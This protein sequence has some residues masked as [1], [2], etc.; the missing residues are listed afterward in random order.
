MSDDNNEANNPQ[1]SKS[2]TSE[3][4]G[5][6]LRRERVTRRIAVETIAKDLKLN[7]AY[8]KAIE[9]NNFDHLPASPYVRVYLRSIANYLMLN[10]DEILEKYNKDAGTKDLEKDKIETKRIK[11]DI[12]QD[13]QKSSLLWNISIILILIIIGV[14]IYYVGKKMNWIQGNPLN[15]NDSMSVE[16]TYQEYAELADSLNENIDSVSVKDTLSDIQDSIDSNMN[17]TNKEDSLR[18]AIT[19]MK[20]SVWIQIFFDGKSWKNFIKIGQTRVFYA[21]DSL[22]THVGRNSYLKYN[23]NGKRLRIKGQ[24]VRYF[25]IDHDGMET[26]NVDQ[27]NSIFKNRL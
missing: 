21:K 23:L 15:K 22:N 16:T 5:D 27:W 12:K 4:V 10:S 19:A 1:Q 18:F 9:L 13:R 20:D 6:I 8:I 25:R 7:I 11:I 2:P 26:W 17:K 14:V 24:G 3:K